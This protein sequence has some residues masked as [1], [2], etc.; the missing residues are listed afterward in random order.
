MNLHDLDRIRRVYSRIFTY[1]IDTREDF[2][3]N[4]T[5]SSPETYDKIIRLLRDLYYYDV[6]DCPKVIEADT[7][8]SGKYK[9]YKFK[10]D[11]FTDSGDLLSA[12]YGLSSISDR[13][14]YDI[15]RCLSDISCKGSDTVSNISKTF[16]C[17]DKYCDESKDDGDNKPRIRR[18]LDNLREYG[19]MAKKSKSYHINDR[20][21]KITDDDLIMLYYLASFFSGAG[22]PRVAAV[23]LRK[24]LL[25]YINFRGLNA[26]TDAFLFRDSICANI[27]D[28]QVVYILMEC[29][30]EHRRISAEINAKSFKLDPVYLKIDTKLGRW[31]LFA[32]TD[33]NS[34]LIVRVSN[35]MKIK[36]LPETFDYDKAETVINEKLKYCYISNPY[37][38][39][40]GT[41]LP[42][43][44]EAE[45][46]F[47]NKHIYMR[48]QFEREILV[49]KI[50]VR[51]ESEIYHAEIADVNE[52]KPFLRS[53]A[54]YIKVLPSEEHNLDKELLNE[55]E[56]ML[57][58]YESVQ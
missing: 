48:E 8:E 47:D 32:L 27:F 7:D 28:E 45:L 5:V 31:Y 15:I 52:L 57:K 1:G 4:E 42:V 6:D 55:Y 13:N 58:N 26:P 54:G 25:R 40:S 9:R 3:N 56:E 36:E 51:D 2:I 18:R 20:L 43:T 12:A 49:G 50:D 33:D 22:Y 44:V 30:S 53:Y 34:P 16:D 21:S 41:K 23:F 14:I 17:D 11:Y 37:A 46:R 10:R 19:Y 35:M 39:V 24:T 29:C 38:T